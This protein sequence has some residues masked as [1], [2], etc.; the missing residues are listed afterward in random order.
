MDVLE[1]E[2]L[3]PKA[4]KYLQ[5]LVEKKL[6]SIKSDKAEFEEWLNDLRSRVSEAPSLEKIQKEIDEVRKLR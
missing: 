1:I 2:I 4:K 3:D 5:E 6:I